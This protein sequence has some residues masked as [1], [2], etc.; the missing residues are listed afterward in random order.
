M[1]Q[2]G[3]NVILTKYIRPNTQY[4]QFRIDSDAY[5]K[6]SFSFFFYF[7]R[8]CVRFFIKKFL[9]TFRNKEYKCK[10]QTLFNISNV[11][12]ISNFFDYANWTD[13]LKNQK[14]YLNKVVLYIIAK[15]KKN[16]R[17][18]I[19]LSGQLRD[20]SYYFQSKTVWVYFLFQR[21]YCRL[22]KY[23]DAITTTR[24]ENLQKK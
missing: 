13:L 17:N 12:C 23:K 6:F 4:H 16:Y 3:E 10:V 18:L 5:V 22:Q 7:L 15:R 21:N 8:Y 24:K 14:D 19:C 1:Q 20:Y 2:I 11:K 9:Y